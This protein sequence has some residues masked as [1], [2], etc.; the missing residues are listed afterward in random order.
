MCGNTVATGLGS[1]VICEQIRILNDS[2]W[3]PRIRLTLFQ[4]HDDIGRVGLRV[5]VCTVL[6][7]PEEL[8]L[9]LLQFLCP[10]Q[11]GCVQRGT[12]VVDKALDEERVIIDESVNWSF[13]AGREPSNVDSRDQ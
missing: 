12:V 7:V 9:D 1:V 3:L 13:P 6:V 11:G 2:I 5:E 4:S 8:V 10:T